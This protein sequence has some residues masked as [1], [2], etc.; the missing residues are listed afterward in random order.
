[1]S[2][3]GF[4]IFLGSNMLSWDSK[5]QHIVT[6]SSIEAKYKAFANTIAE[7]LCLQSLLKELGV[8]LPKPPTLWCDNLGATYLSTNPILRSLTKHMEI[9]FHFVR[10]RVASKHCML[11]SVFHVIK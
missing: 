11:L 8:F 2:T 1:M 3:G 10:D 4:C 6:R 9:D 7:L 5:K